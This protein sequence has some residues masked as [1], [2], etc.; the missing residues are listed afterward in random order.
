[1]AGTITVEDMAKRLDEWAREGD[2]F[3]RD[4]RTNFGLTD[5]QRQEPLAKAA[6]IFAS[7][8]FMPNRDQEINAGPIV[9]TIDSSRQQLEYLRE[10]DPDTIGAWH[11]LSSHITDSLAK[12]MLNDIL[13]FLKYAERH[14]PYKYARSA[15][16]G[17]LASYDRFSEMAFEHKSRHLHDVLCRAAELAGVINAPRDRHQAIAERCGTLLENAPPEDHIWP[18]RVAATLRPEYRP[19]VLP[20][21][22]RDEHAR[23]AS[24]GDAH[25]R[26]L[27]EDLFGIELQIAASNGEKARIRAAAAEVFLREAAIET[28]PLRALA[29]LARAEGWVKG[30]TNE[31]EIIRAIEQRKNDLN[32]GAE[33]KTHN[34]DTSV[35]AEEIEA[36]RNWVLAPD[37]LVDGLD[38]AAAYGERSMGDMERLARGVEALM[39]E[40]PLR[41]LISVVHLSRDDFVCCRP[42]TLEAKR[43]YNMATEHRMQCEIAAHLWIADSLRKLEARYS[44]TPATMGEALARRGIIGE[45]EATGFARAF[46]LYW[47][48]D[49]DSAAHVALP[50]IESTLRRMSEM[51]GNIVT[52]VPADGG[53]RGYKGL[54]R[55]LDDLVPVLGENPAQMLRYMLI[56]NHAMNLRDNY[57]HG[58]RSSDRKVDAAMVLWIAVWLAS[59]Q[60]NA[61]PGGEGSDSDEGHDIGRS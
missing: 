18:I 12:A 15:I 22:I 40:Y 60:P 23:Y 13:W 7:F 19:N 6:S 45:P 27:S 41:N 57:A 38:R 17:Y 32:L 55:V 20:D 1:M 31:S 26:F 28:S 10:H 53:C 37:E 42:T 11:D 33:L 52:F 8:A 56:D 39:G 5:H 51:V 59:L 47:D 49:F 9:A 46:E 21:L 34:A 24:H 36:L 16:D 48:G 25:S 29:H 35:A 54:K 3:D 50:R 30:A 2:P 61:R 43:A 44:A 14:E 58:V 4:P